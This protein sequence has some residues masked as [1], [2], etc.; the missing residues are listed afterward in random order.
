MSSDS[1]NP[2]IALLQSQLN[3]LEYLIEMREEELND[4]KSSTQRLAEMRSM[5]ESNQIDREDLQIK[6]TDFQQKYQAILNR[7]EAME[8]ELVQ[9]IE[10]EKSVVDWEKKN[11]SLQTELEIVLD[12]LTAA[13][14]EIEELT[15]FRSQVVELQS[16][17]EMLNQRL[18]HSNE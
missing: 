2:E 8:N 3:D 17:I 16:K 18:Q 15:A 1:K 12:E 4:L 5:L 7:E 10:Q 14:K 13:R 11:Q 9:Y 6:E